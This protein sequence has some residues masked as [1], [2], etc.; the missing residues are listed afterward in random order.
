MKFV[1]LVDNHNRRDFFERF[2]KALISNGHDVTFITF[3]LSVFL[4]LR[5][6][7]KNV[8]LAKPTN[9]RYQFNVNRSIEFLTK[10]LS[11]SEC[12][13]L[14][15]SIFSSLEKMGLLF[16]FEG[17]FIWNGTN[18]S[19]IAVGD[20]CKKNSITCCY[21]EISNLP[22]RLFADSCGVNANSSIFR[23]V[24]LL[25]RY[26]DDISLYED[27][28]SEF[29]KYKEKNISIPQVKAL[30]S[31]NYW[32]FFDRIFSLFWI[33]YDGVPFIKKISNKLL[34][35]RPSYKYS[36]ELPTGDFVFFPLQVSSDS[37]ILIN[38]DIGLVD[39][40]LL[41]NEYAIEKNCSLVIKPHPAENNPTFIKK[42]NQL[43]HFYSFFLVNA[44]TFELLSKCKLAITINSSV[45]LE[46]LIIGKDVTFLGRSF[47]RYFD[48]IRLRK[49]IL[50]YLFMI[51]YFG[52]T[53]M[54][55]VLEV[56]RLVSRIFGGCSDA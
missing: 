9:K 17:A 35:R 14:Y 1:I 33:P 20:W 16:K 21:L 13:K 56:Q 2:T 40:I 48:D 27:W 3:R 18:V 43:S 50:S 22:G 15:S 55:P 38:S 49:Y 8:Y 36:L 30:H 37:Q 28:R 23:N 32:A 4:L 44:G 12:L 51:D 53:E 6:K 19:G 54:I 31:L 25:D 29:L 11:E 24:E 52:S 26:S 7:F 34:L 10:N 45:G 41:A 5:V 47:F 46:S 42:L 39:A